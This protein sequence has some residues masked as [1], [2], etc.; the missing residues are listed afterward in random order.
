MDGLGCS[1]M[2]DGSVEPA[3]RVQDA[4]LMPITLLALFGSQAL[5]VAAALALPVL[6]PQ[7]TASYGISDR[8][9][10]RRRYRS[11]SRY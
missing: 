10:C 11:R 5:V 8:C 7:V 9:F 1:S 4:T 2:P 6:A 3:V